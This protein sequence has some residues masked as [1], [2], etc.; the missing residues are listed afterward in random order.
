VT[1]GPRK[2]ATAAQ[3]RRAARRPTEQYRSHSG[4][5]N[6]NYNAVGPFSCF[7]IKVPLNQIAVKPLSTKRCTPLIK[8]DSSLAR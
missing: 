8:R 6:I 5:L 1:D 7:N 2:L 4:R 3:S